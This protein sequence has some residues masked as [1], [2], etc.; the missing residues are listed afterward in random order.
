M[1][2]F[3]ATIEEAPRGGAVVEVP[4]EV[5][6]NLGGGGRIP[7]WASFDGIAYQGS[8]VTYS[9]RHIIGVL[10]TIR[11][12]LGKSPGDSLAIAVE[13]DGSERKVEIPEELTLAFDAAP[14]ARKAFEALSYSHQRQHVEHIVAAKQPETRK[15]RALRTVETLLS[16]G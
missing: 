15:R 16:E 10:K 1:I 4:S 9:G 6:E 12:E 13:R 3:Q 2:T 5:V 14:A 11:D 8:I 7:V